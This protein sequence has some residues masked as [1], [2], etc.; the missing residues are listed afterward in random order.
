MNTDR[1]TTS[2]RRRDPSPQLHFL[3]DFEAVAIYLE[4]GHFR[5]YVLIRQG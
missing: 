1:E 2:W 5:L 4:A 3:L